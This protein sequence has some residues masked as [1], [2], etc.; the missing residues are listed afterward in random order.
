MPSKSII[1]ERVGSVGA[2]LAIDTA[3]MYGIY[4]LVVTHMLACE[5][6]RRQKYQTP[7]LST[8]CRSY[9]HKVL[10]ELQLH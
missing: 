10:P 3:G 1:R 5:H 8:T 2:M 9:F 7:S 4:L 6:A